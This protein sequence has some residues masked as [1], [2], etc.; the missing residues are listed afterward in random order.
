MRKAP[1][2]QR[3]QATVE[4]ILQAAAHILGRR[5]W[6]K[7]TTNEVAETAGVSIGS[8]Y[9]YFPNKL[10][11]AEAIRERHLQQVL[12]ALAPLGEERV[13]ATSI[14]ELASRLVDVV[15][16]V[17]SIDQPLHRVLLEEV[18]LAS[19]SSLQRYEAEYELRYRM[20]I[21]QAAGRRRSRRDDI[22]ARVLAGAVEGVVHGA[23]RRGELGSPQM[24]RELIVLVASYLRSR[25]ELPGL[26]R[27][28]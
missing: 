20:V 22:A 5:G 2:Q 9:Q 14:E 10:A 26:S 12:G 19:R 3:A 8:L 11:L 27:T 16:A 25:G 21:G 4:A 24:R 7:F 15:V 18:P 28:A 13:Q 1:T 17:H 6:L 23:A